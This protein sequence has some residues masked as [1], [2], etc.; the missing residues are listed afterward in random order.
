[1]NK[2]T[3]DIFK[4]SVCIFV[5]ASIVKTHE[6]Q[7]IGCPGCLVIYN[8]Q[9]YYTDFVRLDSSNNR[10]E[11]SAVELGI[12]KALQ[13]RY[14]GKSINLF[15][16]SKLCIYSIR[17]WIFKWIQNQKNSVLYGS[18]AT[19]VMNQDIIINIVNTILYNN[20]HINLYHQKGHVN[21][22][23]EKSLANARDVFIES[24]KIDIDLQTLQTISE[25]NNYVDIRT[26]NT[27]DNCIVTNKKLKPSIRFSLNGFDISKYSKLIRRR[28]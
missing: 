9:Q 28:L 4:N 5:D 20:L 19:P 8:E 10:S 21:I 12:E 1:M 3:G 17:E 6:Q 24:N 13:F 15:S 27:L 22:N 2:I 25:F 11:L 7:Y 26:K 23:N 18:S 16:D 14:L